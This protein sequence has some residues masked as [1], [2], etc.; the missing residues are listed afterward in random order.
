MITYVQNEAVF[1]GSITCGT[2]KGDVVRW[3]EMP[4]SLTPVP[5]VGDEAFNRA[6]Y[7]PRG[8]S[9]WAARESSANLTDGPLLGC[10]GGWY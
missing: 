8:L 9:L 3:E 10:Q 2:T 5:Q 4:K 1:V 6:F 7:L